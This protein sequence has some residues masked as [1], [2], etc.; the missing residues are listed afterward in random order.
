LKPLESESKP[1]ASKLTRQ[2]SEHKT[3]LKEHLDQE[4]LKNPNFKEN[5]LSEDILE[6]RSRRTSIG[7][8]EI[9][10]ASKREAIAVDPASLAKKAHEKNQ[11]AMLRDTLAP[12]PPD[13]QNDHIRNAEEDYLFQSSPPGTEVATSDSTN[14]FPP[15]GFTSYSNKTTDWGALPPSN[16]IKQLRQGMK[17]GGHGLM[18]LPMPVPSMSGTSQ[19]EE[20]KFIAELYVRSQ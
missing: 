18:S 16:R 20:S 13:T 17:D 6:L 19:N 1:L 8:P 14:D 4:S 12:S 2:G 10:M 3:H 11:T 9:N 5:C 7:K 15:A